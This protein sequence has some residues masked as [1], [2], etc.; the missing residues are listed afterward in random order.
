MNKRKFPRRL[1]FTLV[2]VYLLVIVAPGIIVYPVDWLLMLV[3]E[4]NYVD[5]WTP[6]SMA[7][8]VFLVSWPVIIVILVL[9]N[10]FLMRKK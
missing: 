8:T 10:L 2:V 3:Y 5:G 6:G 1:L 4:R 9:Y 7:Y